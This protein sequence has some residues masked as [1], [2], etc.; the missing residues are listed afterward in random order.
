MSPVRLTWHVG[1]ALSGAQSEGAFNLLA[2]APQHSR[3]VF[4]DATKSAQG[5]ISARL[6]KFLAGLQAGAALNRF[7][8][9]ARLI[10]LVL[11]LALPLNL[12][13]VGVIWGLVSQATDAQRTSERGAEGQRPARPPW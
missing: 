8:I 7:T 6:A 11:A 10:L 4:R 1:R 12:V 2:P 5:V 13:I 9:S 3:R